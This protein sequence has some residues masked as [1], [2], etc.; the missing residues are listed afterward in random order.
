[1]PQTV[2]RCVLTLPLLTEPW[3]E[4]ILEKRF[5]IV[6]HLQNSL[7]SYQLRRL[8][9]LEHSMA[10]R[11]LAQKIEE[12]PRENRKSLYQQRN[13]MLKEAGFDQRIFERSI[14][15]MQKH[16]AEHIGAQVAHKAASDVW[17]SFE[18]YL[19]GS[20]KMVHFKRRGSLESVANKKAGNCMA[21]KDGL[22]IWSGG[23]CNHS[24]SPQIKSLKIKVAH[25]QTEYEKE[26]L[27]KECKYFR[28]VR[29][30]MKNRYKYY[31]QFTLVGAPV[32]KPRIVSPGRVGI[33]IGTQSIAVV[34]E[35]AV[36]L[37]ELADQV[38]DNHKKIAQLQ[39][40]MDASRRCSN[41][42][43]Y[44][45]DGTI[46]RGIRLYW[47][48]SKRYIRLAGKVRE[49]QR[50]NAAIR[51]YQHICLANEIIALGTEVYVND[52][53]FQLLA[54][55]PKKTTTT[56]SKQCKRQNRFGKSVAD[57]APAMLLSIL[58]MKLKSLGYDGIYRVDTWKFKA[59][60]YDHVSKDYQP[61][62]LS[63]RTHNLANGDLLQRDL[64]SAFLLMNSDPTLQHPDQ[65]ACENSY[66]HFKSLHD[67]E[68]H[69]LLSDG[70]SHLLSFGLK[71]FANCKLT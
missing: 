21:Y 62:S 71:Q 6:E 46:R 54:Q 30:W 42:D 35:K 36:C 8:K 17:R 39:R 56:S 13:K 2:E 47:V 12:T 4:H 59:S 51:K 23:R 29:K 3:Q 31:L 49:L 7:I 37:R 32:P 14:E 69:S 45:P 16:F 50:K 57:K 66:S 1:M 44:N 34:S 25:P 28:V 26:M 11:E 63:K 68:I 19:F 43:N 65:N 60:Q 53:D 52:I 64:Y 33:D 41:P 70:K 20:G 61:K 15:P 24:V 5:K 48:Y 38:N 40:K 10:Y 9:K 67:E 55:R 22:F 27:Q 58:D 18:K